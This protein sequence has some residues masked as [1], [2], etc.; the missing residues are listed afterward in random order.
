MSFYEGERIGLITF[1]TQSADT[2]R[3]MNSI[4]ENVQRATLSS[5]PVNGARIASTVLNTPKF[6]SQWADDLVTMSSRIRTMRKVLYDELVRLQTPGDWSHIVE[7]S[8][9][10]GYTGLLPK[11]I[12]HLEGD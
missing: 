1:I 8:G 4:L 2:T 11:Q 10:F 12:E 9:M 6:A 7:Q 3:T 5:P